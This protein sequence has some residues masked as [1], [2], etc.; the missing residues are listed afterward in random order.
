MSAAENTHGDISSR[1]FQQQLFDWFEKR[2]LLSELRTFMRHRMISAL[3]S[4]ETPCPGLRFTSDKSSSVSPSLQAILL[5]I[6]EFLVKQEYHYTMSIFVAEAPLIASFPK[7]SGYVSYL[8]EYEARK[9]GSEFP[10]YSEKDVQDIM[11]V[12]GI[13]VGSEGMDHILRLYS[14]NNAREPLLV[15]ALTALSA[16]VEN[17][18]Q[19]GDKSPRKNGYQKKEDI[20]NPTY[21]IEEIRLILLRAKL[22]SH[23]LQQV[24]DLLRKLQAETANRVR[25]TE[26]EKHNKLM[27]I[28]EQELLAQALVQEEKIR[29]QHL[30][31]EEDLRTKQKHLEQVTLQL[32]QQHDLV[33]ERLGRVQRH[34][35][36]IKQQ[37][38][39]LMEKEKSLEKKQEKLEEEHRTLAGLRIEL[40]EAAQYL[41]QEHS[42]SKTI[43]ELNC[44]QKRCSQLECEL[45]E[46]KER[47]HASDFRRS[48]IGIQT[49]INFEELSNQ[50]KCLTDQHDAKN[51]EHSSSESLLCSMNEK[52]GNNQVALLKRVLS[53]LQQENSELKAIATQQRKR[54]DELTTKAADLANHIAQKTE[55][56]SSLPLEQP[57]NTSNQHQEPTIETPIHTS[58]H[59]TSSTPWYPL[60][61]FTYAAPTQ[62]KDY[63]RKHSKR[64]DVNRSVTTTSLSSDESPTEEVLREARKRLQKL[65][66]ESEAVDR[67]YRDFRAR[68][69]DVTSTT[70]LPLPF[71]QPRTV[72]NVMHPT[73]ARMD[74]LASSSSHHTASSFLQTRSFSS[75]LASIRGLQSGSIKLSSSSNFSSRFPARAK[76]LFGFPDRAKQSFLSSQNISSAQELLSQNAS[77]MKLN[78]N[79]LNVINP[80]VLAKLSSVNS[81]LPQAPIETKNDTQVIESELQKNVEKT[82]SNNSDVKCAADD[83]ERPSVP[84]E[85]EIS[86]GVFKFVELNVISEK[87]KESTLESKHLENAPVQDRSV[88]SPKSNAGESPGNK[89][90]TLHLLN[91]QNS[92]SSQ[93]PIAVESTERL[94][95][96]SNIMDT[97]LNEISTYSSSPASAIVDNEGNVIHNRDMGTI[98]RTKENTENR[99]QASQLLNTSLSSIENDNLQISGGSVDK[100]G[101]DDDDFW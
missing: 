80:Q 23:Q 77:T 31:T 74:K 69:A 44:L 13:T 62:G 33:L 11:E 63:R 64:Y 25:K 47:L 28:R 39:A 54:I 9:S 51:K 96:K 90:E 55:T 99:E 14:N 38:N 56:V 36:E 32:R 72:N 88:Q 53:R 37:E 76:M 12:F 60:H 89:P 2:G 67:S 101:E 30:A 70:P 27:H 6:V 15:C 8:P 59:H 4:S 1:E 97:T 50:E 22:T 41:R 5:L 43:F 52:E 85:K 58:G 73:H 10:R 82:E 75:P 20:C 91:K 65:E 35:D 34:A 71:S 81:S 45:K 66:E 86:G 46:T 19:G 57:L 87:S 49:S 100:K 84:E 21:W 92:K 83:L 17:S 7:F 68:Q 61:S 29:T 26:S 16:M 98:Q 79:T 24:E 95:A 93:Q 48:D 18:K 94:P 42:D 40:Q 78:A 3:Y